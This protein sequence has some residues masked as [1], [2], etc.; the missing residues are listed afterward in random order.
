MIRPDLIFVFA[1]MEPPS[2]PNVLF[3]SVLRLREDGAPIIRASILSF[4]LI[5]K[6]VTLWDPA[7]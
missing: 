6:K 1:F 4:R 5:V 2:L 7:E 3:L